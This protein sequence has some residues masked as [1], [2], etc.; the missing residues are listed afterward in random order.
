VAKRVGY[1]DA[2]SSSASN[3]TTDDLEVKANV[4]HI[5]SSCYPTAEQLPYWSVIAA[6]LSSRTR[7]SVAAVAFQNVTPS[8]LMSVF[9]YFLV[10]VERLVI[11]SHL[12]FCAFD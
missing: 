2:S 8:C 5:V 4:R 11:R 1:S 7:K 6:I 12:S 9:D 10:V 3:P